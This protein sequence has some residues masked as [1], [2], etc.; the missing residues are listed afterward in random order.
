MRM[1]ANG[2]VTIPAE[3]RAKFNLK[4]GDEL[5]V[6]EDGG[7]LRIV[8]RGGEDSPGERLVR[9]MRRHRFDNPEVAELTTDEI[10]A[11]LRD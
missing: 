1:N 9:Q 5:D 10:M 3:L 11:L 2:Q 4:E 8:V 7:A 6:I